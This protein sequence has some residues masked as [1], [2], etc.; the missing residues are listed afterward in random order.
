[1]NKNSKTIEKYDVICVGGGIMSGTLALILKLLEPDLKIAILERA[2]KVATESTGSMNNAGTGH[3][4]LCEL[5]YTPQLEDGTIDVTK[6]LR[7]FEQFEQSKQFWAY[8]VKENLISDPSV[9]VHPMP[10]HSWVTGKEDISFLKKR[11][12][13]LRNY[14]IF[15]DME[16]TEDLS[17]M[18]KWFPLIANKRTKS[19]KMAAT[20]MESGTEMNFETLTEEYFN[21][22]KVKF[23]LKVITNHEVIDIDINCEKGWTV[24]AKNLKNNKRRYFD[25]P[26]LFI[27]AGG[28]AIPLLQKVDIHEKDGYGGFPISGKWLLCK[29]PKIIEQH[30]AKVYGKAG[31]NAPPMSVPHLDTRYIN[32]ERKLLFGP[33]AGFSTKFLKQGSYFDLPKSIHRNNVPSMWGVFLHN[34]PLTKYL[35]KQVSMTHSD[36]IQELRAF[37]KDAKPEDW[38]EIKAGQRVQIIKRDKERGPVLEFGTDIV[39][40]QTGKITALLGASP[41][42]SVAVNV[43]IEILKI[44]FPEKI[45]TAEWKE[46]LSKIV[47]LWDKDLLNEEELF[48][49]LKKETDTI[50]KLKKTEE[51]TSKHI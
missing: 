46:N 4:A 5:N 34:F 22:L 12:E 38:K 1:M 50:L 9:F 7:I 29:N 51:K 47:P 6:A 21:I 16:Y 26:R 49:K 8:L 33:F 20:R 11:Y 45:K 28:G 48:L 19:E 30:N 44:T 10:H 17:T 25:V 27:G 32:G 18:K 35:L 23:G 2:S 43:I 41:G 39:H 3:S 15:Q 31:V 14:F 37:V 24:K 13:A 42:A 36:R 40:D